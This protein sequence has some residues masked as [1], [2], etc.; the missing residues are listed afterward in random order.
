MFYVDNCRRGLFMKYWKETTQFSYC[1][2]NAVVNNTPG[3]KIVSRLSPDD[4]SD[5]ALHYFLSV[6]MNISNEIILS[7][8]PSEKNCLGFLIVH[9]DFPFI[10]R[11]FLIDCFC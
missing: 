11:Y 2:I 5:T 6:R 1:S 7:R 4:G 3:V 8:M 10:E 9:F